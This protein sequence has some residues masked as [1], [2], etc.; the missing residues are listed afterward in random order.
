MISCPCCEKPINLQPLDAIVERYKLAPME[1]RVLGAVW[2][3]KGMPVITERI[4]DAM[5]VDDPDGG[6]SHGTAYKRFKVAL[7]RLRQRLPGSGIRVE[8][9]SKS[10]GYRLSIE[11]TNAARS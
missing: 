11:V 7:W 2:Q 9:V 4:Y 6:P 3:A 8:Q 5:Y 1:A 10:R